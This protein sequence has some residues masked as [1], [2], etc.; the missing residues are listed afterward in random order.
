MPLQGAQGVGWAPHPHQLNE[1]GSNATEPEP[2]SLTV[3]RFTSRS[4]LP[5]SLSVSATPPNP[6]PPFGSGDP[7]TEGDPATPPMIARK[8]PRVEAV[9]PRRVPRDHLGES[10]VYGRWA[11]RR[12]VGSRDAHATEEVPSPHFDGW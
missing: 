10:P 2:V 4:K 8:G 12:W 6:E 5:T 11:S 3:R 1:R 7:I 9:R